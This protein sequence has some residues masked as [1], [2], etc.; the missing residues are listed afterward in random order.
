[1]VNFYGRD[2]ES[3]GGYEIFCRDHGKGILAYY[4]LL[5]ELRFCAAAVGEDVADPTY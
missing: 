5:A 1:M 2:G 4:T 3:N